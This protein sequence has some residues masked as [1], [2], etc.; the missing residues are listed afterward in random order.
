[1][2]DKLK[3][4]V[5]DNQLFIKISLITALGVIIATLV[6]SLFVI[7]MSENVYLEAYN[8]SNEK[9]MTQI[10]DDYYD[11]HTDIVNV[12]N[13][14]QNSNSLKGYLTNNYTTPSEESAIIYNMKMQLD[15]YGVLHNNTVSNLLLVGM[16][17]KT[18]FPNNTFGVDNYTDIINSEVVKKAFEKPEQITYQYAKDGFCKA[19]K[20][21]NVIIAIKVL[22]DV[23]TK[24][25][26]GLAI[27][28][29]EQNDFSFFYDT[30]VDDKVNHINIVSND[31]L[32]IS[33]N[34]NK[35]GENSDLLNQV[36]VNGDNSESEISQNID[37][38]DYTLKIMNLPFM[39]GKFISMIDETNLINQI[40]FIPPVI[41]TA[42]VISII[43]MTIVVLLIRK[44]LRP[45]N[46]IVA[47]IPEITKGNFTDHIEVAGSGE[48]KE[49]SEGF[50]YMLDG[51]NDYVERIVKLQEE[52]RLTEIHALQMQ[53][54]PHFVYNTLTSIKFLIWQ[55]NKELAIEATDAFIQLLR[56]TLSNKDEYVTLEAE[57]ENIKNYIKIQ[58]I[59]YNN[60]IVITYNISE[61]CKDFL[62]VKMLLQP[63]VENAFFHAFNNQ[64]N[65]TIKIF[66][67]VIKDALTIEIIDNGLGMGQE[68]IDSL[69]YGTV[70]KGKSFSGLGVKNVNKRIKLL[71]GQ[72]YGVTISS[73]IDQGTIVS[74]ALP[75]IVDENL[76]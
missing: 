55:G 34:S 48:I 5:R 29:I 75:I 60:K 45:L 24:A 2:I 25:P 52:K 40:N 46:N 61:T 47:K 76:D 27:I 4:L 35:L 33:S 21:N 58:N 51:L 69:L 20:N 68:Q 37:G 31:G 71:Y 16:N 63:F 62:V 64:E 57:I 43:F 11:L 67:R 26:Y 13:I 65:G 17:G 56:N 66:A 28:M 8:D 38:R 41:A 53:I 70:D 9:I 54:N 36:L 6:V 74:I 23:S 12:L 73:V 14:C 44:A 19:L 18:F 1:M 3:A 22:K 42:I 32:I 30:L 7:Q 10:R 49:L 50:N 72:E 39:D 15:D 59:R